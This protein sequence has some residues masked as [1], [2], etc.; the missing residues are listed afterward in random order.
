MLWITR[1]HLHIDRTACARRIRRF[2]DRDAALH[3]I[4]AVVHDA[5]P[6]DDRCRS[7]QA[8]GSMPSSVA[9]ASVQRPT[10]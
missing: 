4:A 6:D 8:P 1:P 7:P 3:E 10:R 5:D 9:S 2:M